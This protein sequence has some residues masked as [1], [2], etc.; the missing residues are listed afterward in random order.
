MIPLVTLALAALVSAGLILLLRPLL[1]RYALA[2]PNARSSHRVPTPQGGGI[3][4]VG[5]TLAVAVA[6][7]G[8][9]DRM[10]SFGFE[11]AWL[12]GATAAIA[13]VGAV[14]DLRSLSPGL[15]LALQAAAV[16]AVVLA[17][18]GSTRLVPGIPLAL[19]HALAII[20]G[21]WF[22]NLVNFMDGLDWLT[23]AEMAPISA[24][25]A[26]LLWGEGEP[27]AL[28]ALAL[29]GAVLGFAPFNRPVARLF[30]GDVGSLPVGLLVAWLLY[31]LALAHGLAPA[32]LLP[33]Y[34]L[35]DATST[36]L[37]RLARREKVWQAHRSHYYQRATDHGFSVPAVVGHVFGLNLALGVLALA[38]V[39][40]PA[41]PV[42]VA[43]LGAGAALVV[44]VLL[45]FS[46]P[47]QAE[48][49]A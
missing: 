1:A 38:T 20:A 6:M 28:V 18:S 42:Q 24:F 4:V 48:A 41:W 14:D 27:A 33:L 31:K 39:L 9:P 5:A 49:R 25:C 32:I 11:L 26:I 19:E 45:R 29:C 36:L 16:S 35:V 23:V 12:F 21:I 22:V 15:R 30:L 44:L 2:P 46:G 40:W 17:A 47:R 8:M 3:A 7:L 10:G 34:Y 37:R 13:L 43:A